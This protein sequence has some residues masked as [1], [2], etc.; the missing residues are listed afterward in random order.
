M[1]KPFRHGDMSPRNVIVLREKHGESADSPN[2]VNIKVTILDFNHAG[3]LKHP[4]YAKPRQAKQLEKL[5]MQW[6][7]RL[8]SP[9]IRY[10]GNMVEFS[11]NGWCSDA[12]RAADK[13]LWRH[14]RLDDR[15]I[16]VE[17]NPD[18]P[19]IEP[20]YQARPDSDHPSIPDMAVVC[21]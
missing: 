10:H 18:T 14:F 17:W 5:Q 15:F 11:A 6:W 12:H 3:V 21:D 16:P 1:L 4:Y 13:W 19:R 20:C 2:G 7:P 8:V 9:I